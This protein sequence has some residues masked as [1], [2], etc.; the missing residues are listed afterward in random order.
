M[1]FPPDFLEEIKARLPASSVI[2]R[3]VKLKRQGREF[4]G[5]SPFNQEKSASF[6]VNDQ[7]G[8]W[9]DFSAGKNGDIFTFLIETEGLTFPEA[10]ERLAREAG[11][12]MPRND[13]REQ[14][15]EKK[16]SSLHDVM[17]LAATFFE[18]ALQS[19]AG[20]AAR[21]Y[22][23]GRTLP[24]DLQR[25]FRIGYAPGERSALKSY[26]AGKD[27]TQEQMIEAG[28]LIAGDDVPVSFDRFRDRVIFPIADFRGRIVGFGGR[29]LSSDVPAKYLNSPE[30]ELFHKGSLLYNGAEARKAAHDAGT[31]IAVEGYVDVIRMVSAGFAHTVAPLGT[32]LT[33][34]Q[35][36]ILWRMADEPILCF[37]GDK[38]GIRAAGRAAELA[39][40]L[41]APGR[42]L[43]FALLPEGQDPDDL[44]RDAGR[45]AMA[46]VIAAARPLVDL[47]WSRETE[48][49]VFDTPERRAALEARLREIARG[50]G[51]ESVRRHY[52][53]AFGERVAA[54]FPAP[55]RPERQWRGERGR[56]QGGG[57]RRPDHAHTAIPVSDRMTRSGMLAGRSVLPLREVVLVAT[58]LNHPALIA[59][60]LDQFDRVEFT[61]PALAE[62]RSAL[63]ELASADH[64]A[65]AAAVRA[66]LAQSRFSALLGRLDAQIAAAG[67][68]TA[69]AAAA[70]DDAEKG[71][72]QALTLH[73]RQRTLHK[74]L[75]D[76]EAALAGESSE[77]N[78]ARLVDIQKQLANAEGMEALIEGFGS[79]SGR[80]ARAL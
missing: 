9:F 79:M 69:E 52:Q 65:D 35:L 46:E 7:K 59:R 71:W 73:H 28:M 11:V 51:D 2:G 60:H 29:A 13:P 41:L 39:L 43:R 24:P 75:K 23:Q 22:L 57:Q 45:D 78:F 50:I 27:V 53:Q 25:R 74:E 4:A 20:A 47:I 58:M 15:R 56:G 42:S 16:R 14:E 63:L 54:F 72:L 70:D 1:R 49:G 76:A 19:R 67:L 44:I 66:K 3:R 18:E 30:T 36:Q 80:Q 64:E 77:A 55:E 68:W 61:Q 26:L 33:E 17:E 6:F 38:A 34:R 48:Q 8:A 31:V 5:L 12:D 10:V 32:A 37:D 21:G 62:F 40:A